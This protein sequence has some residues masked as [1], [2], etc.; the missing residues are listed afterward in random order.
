VLL[1]G[2]TPRQNVRPPVQS[3]GRLRLW[4]CPGM[5]FR[6][7]GVCSSCIALKVQRTAWGRGIRG[8][9][10]WLTLVAGIGL[11]LFV[12]TACSAAT[13][14]PEQG[15]L[16]VNQGQGFEQVNGPTQVNTGDTIMVGPNG[17]ALVFYP[18]GCKVNVQPG[19]VVTITAVSPCAMGA[20]GNHFD[21][22]ALAVG[23]AGAAAVGFGIYELVKKHS[24][25]TSSPA[26]P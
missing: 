20:Q 22:T 21:T 1:K 25:P 2:H 7:I 8:M 11:G 16:S 17:S 6:E 14:E 18:D 24:T 4:T 12:A 9:R 5:V 10:N 23:G 19:Q 26:S 15:V 3:V 13:V